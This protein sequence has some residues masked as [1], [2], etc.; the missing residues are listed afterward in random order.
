MDRIFSAERYRRRRATELMR[1]RSIGVLNER[2]DAEGLFVCLLPHLQICLLLGFVTIKRSQ[3]RS[4]TDL[5]KS[6]PG[7]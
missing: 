5:H 1:G 7:S 4:G 6:S 3:R 2:I